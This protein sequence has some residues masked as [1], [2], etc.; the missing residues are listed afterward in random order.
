MPL[1][2]KKPALMFLTS[3][4]F[5]RFL[6]SFLALSL[7]PLILV[8]WITLIH[9]RSEVYKQS[10][11]QLRIAADGAEA[12][13][14]EYLNYLK[15]RTA[16]FCSDEFIRNAIV[17]INKHPEDKQ[18]IKHLNHHLVFNKLP[19]FPECVETF[20]INTKGCV[21]ASSDIS[22]IGN[23]FSQMSCFL[24]GQKSLYLS[25]IFRDTKIG[26]IIWVVSAPLTDKVSGEFIGILVNRIHPKTLS[27]IT[28]G[29]KVLA[30]GAKG[31]SMRIGKTGE[32][33]IINRD[34]TMVTESR[35]LDDAILQQPVNTGIVYQ[36]KKL[37]ETSISNYRDYRGVPV[38]GV[39]IIIKEMDW[40]LLTEMDFEEAFIP[41]QKLQTKILVIA[42][43][44]LPSIFFTTCLLT[45]RLT[46]PI[47][48]IIQANHAVLSGDQTIA[49]IPDNEIPNDELGDVMHSRN[50]MLTKLQVNKKLLEWKT[51]VLEQSEE[52]YR[53][54]VENIPAVV[55]VSDREGNIVFI[56]PNVENFCGFTPE[57]FY[58]KGNALWFG[59][60][61]PEDVDLVKRA[62]VLLFDSGNRYDV[63]Y[64]VKRKNGEWMWLNDRAVTTY[65]K[66]GIMYAEGVFSDITERKFA[67]EEIRRLFTA[68]DQSINIVFITDVKGHIEYVNSMFEQVTGYTKREAIGQNP[69]ILASGETSHAEYEELWGTITAGKTWRGIFKNKKKNGQYYWVNGLITPIRNE[70][71]QITNFLAIQ[72]DIT[73]K[74]QSEEK[75][76]YLASYDELTGLRNRTCFMEQ[77]NEWLSHYKSYNQTGVLLLMD[78]D[79]FRFIN[80]T[81]GHSTGDKVLHHV[82]EFLI[83]TLF[84]IDKHHV[85]KD[86][87]ESILGRMG[88]DEFAIFLPAR[89]E[90]EGIETAEEIRKRL[91]KSRFV[92]MPGHV[93]ASIGV[94]LYPR[95]GSTT[96]ELT[97]RADA[98]VYHAK[99]L[100][101]NRIH[102]YHT[103]DLVL[104]KMHSRM[105]WKGRIQ[106]A[107]EEERFEPWFQPIL[108]L[109]DSQI[110]HYEALARMRDT[111]GETILPGAFVD[112]AEMLGLISAIDRI[113]IRKTLKT[114]LNL[115]KQGKVLSLSMNL[116]GKDLD[117]KEFL[118]FLKSAITET[119]A[120]P[121]RLIFEITETAAVRNLDS[122]IKFIRELRLIGCCFSLDDFGVGFTSFKYLKEMEVDYIKIDGSFIQNLHKTQGDH[123]FVK[124][125]ANVAK[126]MGIKTIAEFVENGEIIKILK[127]YGV[128]YAQG[129]FIGKPSPEV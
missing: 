60:I 109:K 108:D 105:E 1:S 74:M 97:T 32:T 8:A 66:D 103:E 51:E 39:S 26:Q 15:H 106:K 21:I 29:R 98:S 91:E 20:I 64:R 27:D 99:E 102:L 9:G 40:I 104:E 38:F 84:E 107:I 75:I 70:K 17:R 101:H 23:D 124:A 48:R 95:D 4:I 44:L 90:K 42:G 41:I 123:I 61:H 16:G 128:D 19:T 111:N 77:L 65:E 53:L 59:R 118:E 56:S 127:D 52:K 3:K 69:R 10:L 100:G 43:I 87:R 88:G 129:Y 83:T 46:K 120:D 86:V 6:F 31:Q 5:R 113:I 78:I 12:Q 76:R 45:S 119:G 22:S 37:G 47:L 116:S 81:Y 115:C 71:G 96:K 2:I 55:W 7:I 67:E 25:D 30:L 63:E 110:H 121:R 93:T 24:N 80:D 122:A 73:E 13:V 49:F 57:E 62:Y 18:I 11:T 36:T 58:E 94:V 125:I 112:T 68:I 126:G 54:L 79:G 72:E 28:T 34:N 33:Y 50:K 14:S 35:F 82:A 89:D 114:L 117:E 85:N 92:E